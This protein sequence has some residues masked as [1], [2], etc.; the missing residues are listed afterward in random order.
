M[1]YT[2]EQLEKLPKWA[3]SEIIRLSNNNTN[4]ESKISEMLGNSDTNTFIIDGLYEKPLINNAIVKF[5][6]NKNSATVYVEKNGKIYVNTDSRTGKRMIILPIA[7]NCFNI[8]FI[9]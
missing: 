1:E 6:T 5:K 8:D 3:K 4:L 2:S 9:D 7:T